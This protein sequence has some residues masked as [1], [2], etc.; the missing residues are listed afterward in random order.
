MINLRI[1]AAIIIIAFYFSNSAAQ[2]YTLKGKIKGLDTGWAFI[3][4]RQTEKADS[5]RI[6]NGIFTITGR[7]S[8]P[9]FCSFGLTINGVKDY[10]LSLFL[11]SG[12]FTMQAD[13]D[14]LNDISILFTGS[15]VEKEFQQFQRRVSR[16]QALNYPEPKAG[17]ALEKIAR[18]YA[19]QHPG[20][21]VS[22][23]ALVSYENDPAK[24]ARM[25]KTLA[26]QIQGSWFGLQ[27]KAK[28]TA[29]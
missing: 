24:L 9:E 16:C 28:L 10:Y 13:K 8:T 3:R 14:S 27:I 1:I 17:M 2:G 21:C 12:S 22:A 18:Q 15:G 19:L 4:H 11:K 6:L 20:S 25:Y 23:F 29:H 5:G 7:A 26:P